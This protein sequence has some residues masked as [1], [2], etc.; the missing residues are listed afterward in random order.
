[1]AG[2]ITSEGLNKLIEMKKKG[3]KLPETWKIDVAN[4]IRMKEKIMNKWMEDYFRTTEDYN[5]AVK[6]EKILHGFGKD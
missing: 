5:S 6:K 3:E 2:I 1:M 4:Y